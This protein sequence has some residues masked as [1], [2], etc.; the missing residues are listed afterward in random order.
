MGHRDAVTQT[1]NLTN[2][3]TEMCQ[4]DGLFD[5][6]QM[7]CGTCETGLYQGFQTL[8]GLMIRQFILDIAIDTWVLI[9]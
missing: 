6:G 7:H 3:T 4:S 8:W 9:K 5:V 1:T 2:S